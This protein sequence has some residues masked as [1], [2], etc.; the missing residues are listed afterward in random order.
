[1]QTRRPETMLHARVREV[2]RVDCAPAALDQPSGKLSIVTPRPRQHVRSFLTVLLV[3]YGAKQIVTVFAFPPFTGH[4]EVAHYAYVRT[5]ATEQRIPVLSE[6]RLPAD[7]A[8]Y[9]QYTL[10][11][12]DEAPAPQY[13]A[14][15]PP[16]YYL[17]MAPFYWASSDQPI[18]TQQYV[19]RAAAIPFGMLTVLLAYRLTATLFSADTFLLTTVPSFVAFQPQVSYEA[20]MVN[21]DIVAIALYSWILYLI[22][23]GVRDRFPTGTCV[24][25]GVVLGCALLTKGTAVTAVPIIGTALLVAGGRS[26][27]VWLRQAALVATPALLLAA[28]W[29]AFLYR[30]YGNFSAFPQIA[31]LQ[32]TWNH[33]EGSFFDLLF[34]VEFATLRFRETWGQF[35]W[36]QIPLDGTLLLI[37]GVPLLLATAGTILYPLNAG[38]ATASGDY[39]PV[40]TPSPWQ[41][42]SLLLLVITCVLSY[43]AVVQFGTRFVFTQARYYF[44]AVNAAAL[45]LMLGLRTLIPLRYQPYGQAAVF[46]GLFLL[47][48]LI[49]TRYVIP[50]YGWW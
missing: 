39:D 14:N 27:G 19:L 28:P 29:Y 13:V 25:C 37:I 47:N 35:G 6:D 22:V 46:C 23:V 50:H 45:L 42:I 8:P 11:W 7:L 26:P 44:P 24:A 2:T 9:S 34:R 40:A 3:V 31:K 12:T 18:T 41:A 17:L 5:L 1:M 33:P 48:V 36:Q 30:T 21:N 16:L 38:W 15:H 10:D 32:E 49:F 20:A 43:F 4:D